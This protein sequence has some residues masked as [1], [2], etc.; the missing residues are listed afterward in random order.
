MDK[1]LMLKGAEALM[2]ALFESLTTDG[3]SFGRVCG[4]WRE[5]TGVMSD[6][7]PVKSTLHYAGGLTVNNFLCGGMAM[8]ANG[9]NLGGASRG[10]EDELKREVARLQS[11]LHDVGVETKK[12]LSVL[13]Y[14]NAPGWEE[15]LDVHLCRV[16][17]TIE[18]GAT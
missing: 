3:H 8:E 17:R 1:E 10:L 5:L 9:Q 15:T 18:G 7:L 13:R 14:V 2:T 6:T 12:A 4:R 11:Q 16:L